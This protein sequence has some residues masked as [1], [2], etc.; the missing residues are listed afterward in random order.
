MKYVLSP[1]FMDSVDNISIN[2]DIYSLG[3]I[4]FILAYKVPPA[5]RDTV[6]L[7]N[8]FISKPV[9]ILIERMIIKEVDRRINLSDLLAE[10]HRIKTSQQV[11]N[12]RMKYIESK[13]F[14]P[15]VIA[16]VIKQ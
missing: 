14:D 15:N 9:K 8:D 5:R 4:A 6:P 16:A 7:R 1:E 2:S 11:E 12:E 10:I 13:G 3:A